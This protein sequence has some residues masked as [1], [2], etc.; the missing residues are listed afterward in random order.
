MN[1]KSTIIVCIAIIIISIT[2]YFLTQNRPTVISS[3]DTDQHVISNYA[4]PEIPEHPSGN[5]YGGYASITSPQPFRITQLSTPYTCTPFKTLTA[6]SAEIHINGKTYCVQTTS[7]GYAHG[8][9]T[10]VTYTYSTPVN[11]GSGAK[12]VTFD[13]EYDGCTCG[14]GGNA[15]DV[16][17]ELH[18]GFEDTLNTTVSKLMSI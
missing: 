15:C 12:S 14:V 8:G 1:K 17:S 16:C 10:Y 5:T 13:T 18:R 4:I 2:I 7:D 3:K 9:K 6:Q 11:N